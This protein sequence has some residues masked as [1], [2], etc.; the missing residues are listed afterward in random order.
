VFCVKEFGS[1]KVP[2][3]ERYEVRS[4]YFTHGWSPCMI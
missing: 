3:L 2:D 4:D 1:F